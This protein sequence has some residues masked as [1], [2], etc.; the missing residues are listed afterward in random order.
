MF[1]FCGGR[2]V[3]AMKCHSCNHCSSYSLWMSITYCTVINM[4]PAKV[5]GFFY[6][7]K[8]GCGG[9]GGMSDLKIKDSC[10]NCQ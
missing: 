1:A 3:G 8:V 4:I 7:S 2:V 10:G 5:K 6:G 9:G